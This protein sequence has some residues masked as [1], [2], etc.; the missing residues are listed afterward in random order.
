MKK[1]IFST[2]VVNTACRWLSHVILKIIGWKVVSDPPERSRYVLVAAPHTSNWDFLLLIL[3]A[4]VTRL[5]VHWMGKDTLFPKPFAGFVRWMGGVAIDRSR[6]NNTVEQMVEHFRTNKELVVVIPPEG[7][8][9]AVTRWKTG[10]YHIANGAN[11]PLVLSYIDT[12][13]K[14]MGFGETFLTTGEI[15]KDMMFIQ[16]FYADKRGFNEKPQ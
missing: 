14:T 15:E 3:A 1:T 16:S 4:F 5:D 11:V 10:F 6:S 8:R 9:S 13:T 2:P 12:A 7:T